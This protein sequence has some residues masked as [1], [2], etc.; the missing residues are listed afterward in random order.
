[1]DEGDDEFEFDLFIFKTLF[2]VVVVDVDGDEIE[3]FGLFL[4]I[5]GFNK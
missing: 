4:S 1:M 5:K 3:L 2:A